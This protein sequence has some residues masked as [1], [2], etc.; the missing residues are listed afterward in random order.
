MYGVGGPGPEPVKQ[1][2]V[3]RPSMMQVSPNATLTQF[4]NP[5]VV[6]YQTIYSLGCIT[7]MADDDMETR[8]ELRVQSTLLIDFRLFEVL[9]RAGERR[10]L[11]GS[12]YGQTRDNARQVKDDERRRG[13]RP[14]RDQREREMR[15]NTWT[16]TV[17]N[18]S[19]E[20]V[21]GRASDT[22]L[23]AWASSSSK[24]N[25]ILGGRPIAI[26]SR[27]IYLIVIVLLRQL[28]DALLLLR[29]SRPTAE[30]ATVGGGGCRGSNGGE[31]SLTWWEEKGRLSGRQ[32]RVT[33]VAKKCRVFEAERHRD[34]NEVTILGACAVQV[35]CRVLRGWGWGRGRGRDAPMREADVGVQEDAN[36]A[37]ASAATSCVQYSTVSSVRMSVMKSL[38]VFT[39]AVAIFVIGGVFHRTGPEMM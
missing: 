27:L 26:P 8:V 23:Q 17:V 36:R 3:Q 28:D 30:T 6:Q 20:L 22:W 21:R 39:H 31:P 29:E 32:G 33:M 7:V 25:S 5:E 4:G 9:A 19:V 2:G 13:E 38:V 1:W 35:H 15:G 16:K 11:E 18:S 14:R 24:P 12:I 34:E 37:D 10:K